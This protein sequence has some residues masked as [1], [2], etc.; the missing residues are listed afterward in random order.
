ME[1]SGLRLIIVFRGSGRAQGPV[2]LCMGFSG[3]ETR[4]DSCEERM[5]PSAP[6]T[7]GGLL[8]RQCTPEL[9]YLLNNTKR[10]VEGNRSLGGND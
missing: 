10:K 3:V 5:T 9:L 1:T 2:I 8:W 7:V 4:K 6:A